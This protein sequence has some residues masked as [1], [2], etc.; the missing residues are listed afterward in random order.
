MYSQRDEETHILNHFKGKPVGRFL[1]IGAYHPFTFSNVRALYEKGFGGVLIEPN[2]ELF[3]NL[4]DEYRGI[5]EV[6]VVDYCI[7]EETGHATFYDNNGAV[8]TL[9]KEHF[10]KWKDH[11]EFT[12]RQVEVKT[13]ADFYAEHPGQYDFINID[14]EGLDMAILKQINLDETG[15]S[16][17][18]IEFNGEDRVDFVDYLGV[19]GFEVIHETPE[20]LLF[21]R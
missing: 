16:L 7:G 17:V 15:T 1:D 3:H 6:F 13:F 14:V 19:F 8:A 10:E 9:S 4:V 11:A 20:N 12:E 21:A 2:V 18:C 5:S